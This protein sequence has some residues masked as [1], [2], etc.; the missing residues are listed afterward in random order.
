MFKKYMEE[1]KYVFVF[2]RDSLSSFSKIEDLNWVQRKRRNKLFFT[3]FNERQKKKNPE[4]RLCKYNSKKR[5]FECPKNI[6]YTLE[7][8]N[9]KNLKSKVV[10]DIYDYN[11]SYFVT[12]QNDISKLHHFINRKVIKHIYINNYRFSGD[13]I[14]FDD[15]SAVLVEYGDNEIYERVRKGYVK[16]LDGRNIFIKFFDLFKKK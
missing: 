6:K 14:I 15:M 8:R 5:I 4:T 12:Q 11:A 10:G 9:Y 16:K 7:F 3:L 1:G 13:F 2:E